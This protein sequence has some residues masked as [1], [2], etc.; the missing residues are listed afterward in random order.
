MTLYTLR[1]TALAFTCVVAA[2]GGEGNAST[3][4]GK[5]GKGGAGEAS[6]AKQTP[7]GGGGGQGRSPTVLG[8]TDVMTV[9]LGDIEEAIIVS[10]DLKPIEEIAVRS[11]MDGDLVRVLVREGDRVVRGQ[12]LAEFESLIQEGDRASAEAEREAS[13]S[14]VANAQWNVDQSAELLKAGAIPERDLRAAQQTLAAATAR[15]A[16]AEA[17]LRGVSRTVDDTRILSPTTGVVATR[18]AEVGER[19]ARGATLFNV[20][21]NNVLELEASVPARLAGSLRPNQVVRFAAG[22]LQLE[23]RVARI[24]PTINVQN[25]TLT[26]YVQVPNANGALRGNSFAT[27]RVVTQL[28]AN[29]LTIP[30]RA[31]RQ[32][33]GGS[34]TFVYRIVDDVVDI[35]PITLGVT[36]EQSGMQQITSGLSV[37]DRIVVG[38]LSALGRGMQV[39]IVS[40]DAG[41]PGGAR[42]VGAPKGGSGA[43]DSAARAARDTSSKR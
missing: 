32:S 16:A 12:V 43:V 29:T 7:G 14:D 33:Q 8:P 9:S 36:D 17:R 28:I 10:G 2:C 41:G 6:A 31:V 39:R 23:G 40:D 25:R 1:F 3:L 35:A 26:V 37:G 11:R 22:G 30:L 15:L 4:A 19:I 34:N 24:S 42:Q 18:S 13:K 38:N 27:G 21:R 20:V 5:D